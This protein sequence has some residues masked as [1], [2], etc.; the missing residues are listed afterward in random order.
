MESKQSTRP[1][2]APRLVVPCPECG[3][4]LVVRTNRTTSERFLGCAAY[5]RCAATQQLTEWHQKVARGDPRLP[6][7]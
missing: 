6:G 4:E 5:P 2:R 3:G 1:D 7:F